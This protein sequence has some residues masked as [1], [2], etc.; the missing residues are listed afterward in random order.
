MRSHEA[1]PSVVCHRRPSSTPAQTVFG[2][3]LA[4][5]MV[6]IVPNALPFLPWLG[7][8]VGLNAAQ[9]WPLSADLTTLLQPAYMTFGS[10]GSKTI[11]VNQPRAPA[12]RRGG[13]LESPP[14]VD[15]A[16][17]P[18]CEQ[19]KTLFWSFGLISVARPSPPP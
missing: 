10:V 11:G 17:L 12:A 18:Y 1:P 19:P 14:S 13:L 16:Q 2:G 15:R 6:V 5:A 7:L 8:R 4:A 3:L 9:V